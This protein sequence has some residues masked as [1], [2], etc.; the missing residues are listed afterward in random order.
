MLSKNLSLPLFFSGSSELGPPRR[1]WG[2]CNYSPHDTYLWY[3][4]S[5]TIEIYVVLYL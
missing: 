4:V 5:L 2:L 3:L 1:N